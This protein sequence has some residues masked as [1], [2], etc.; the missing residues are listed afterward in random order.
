MVAG[1]AE[2]AADRVAVFV[3]FVLVFG[4]T[5]ADDIVRF[6][7]AG[8]GHST[9]YPR[10][11]LVVV[12]SAL[13]LAAALLKWRVLARTSVSG[14]VPGRQFV[15]LL[16]KSWWPVGAVL[17]LAVELVMAGFGSGVLADL[18]GAVVYTVA[19]SLL[20]LAAVDS[21]PTGHRDRRWRTNSWILPLAVGT[22][23]V[24]IA[25]ALWFPVINSS[26]HCAGEVSGD[27]FA[28]MV[29]VLPMLLVA[30]GIE[31]GFLRRGT[32]VGGGARVV[33]VFT[34]ALLGVAEVL[35]FSMLVRAS[36]EAC[37]LPATLHQYIAFMLCVQAAAIALATLVWL[38][39]ADPDSRPS[40]VGD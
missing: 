34:V 10:W 27:F 4:L 28:Q 21:G 37:G 40:D 2:A 24:Q 8:A 19:M 35:A 14:S 12:N 33:P 26:G 5:Y 9:G 18:V 3:V 17:V 30:L 13:V 29:Q 25:S 7:F 22:L 23:I 6:S 38:L 1:R 36:R 11:I 32:A 39:L 15:A 16:L 20:L 31:M